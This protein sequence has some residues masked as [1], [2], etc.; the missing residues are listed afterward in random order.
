MT[1]KTATPPKTPWIETPLVKSAT[2]SRA[3][4]W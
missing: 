1:V 3:A 4:G 2:L